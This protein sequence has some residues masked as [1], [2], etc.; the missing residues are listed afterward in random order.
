MI[1]DLLTLS[2]A[3]HS[4]ASKKV[5]GRA[6]A[7]VLIHRPWSRFWPLNNP[8]QVETIIRGFLKI[9]CLLQMAQ[10][11]PGADNSGFESGTPTAPTQCVTGTEAKCHSF[12]LASPMRERAALR[13]TCSKSRDSLHRV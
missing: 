8:W 7:G 4:S 3:L 2:V 11:Q 6:K 10:E 12:K 9:A 1:T 5:S 13:F